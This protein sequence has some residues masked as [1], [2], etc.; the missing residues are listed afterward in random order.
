MTYDQEDNIHETEITDTPGAEDPVFSSFKTKFLQK[1]GE[2]L[3]GIGTT[4]SGKTHKAYWLLKQLMPYEKCIWFDCGKSAQMGA[5]PEIGPLFGMGYPVNI[6][7]PWGCDVTVDNSPVQVTI[8][9]APSAPYFWEYIKPG[10][11]NIGIINRFIIEPE[12]YARYISLAYKRLIEL[13]QPG[14]FPKELL[15]LAIIQDEFQDV[16]PGQTIRLNKS[17][18]DSAIRISWNINKLRSCGIRLCGFTQKYTFIYPNARIAFT[19]IMACRGAYF[20][21]DD[22]D[23]ADFNRMYKRLDIQQAV[24]WFPKKIFRHRW[25]F[26]RYECPPDL[27]VSFDG[28]VEDDRPAKKEKKYERGVQSC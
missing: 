23:L 24:M 11:I 28:L 27:K 19:W 12:V 7:I 20:E 14:R 4:G 2:H 9:K 25:R 8:Q 21:R 18:L 22:P 6:I 10:H 15:P 17:M 3:L 5:E 1:P 13:A 16:A 26:P